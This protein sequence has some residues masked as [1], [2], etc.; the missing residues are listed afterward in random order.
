V[1]FTDYHHGAYAPSD[2][3][4]LCPQ[5]IFFSLLMLLVVFS[6]FFL[7]IERVEEGGTSVSL[8]SSLSLH[9]YFVCVSVFL[10]YAWCAEDACDGEKKRNPT[11]PK[12]TASLSL[13]I[14]DMFFFYHYFVPL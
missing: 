10:C 1:D 8:S 14:N 2:F 11:P 4:V 5:L 7:Y 3:A 9:S 6:F 13:L 12:K